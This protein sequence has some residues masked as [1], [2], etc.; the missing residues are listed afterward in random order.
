MANKRF[1]ETQKA[2]KMSKKMATKWLQNGY[3]MVKNS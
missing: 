1:V 2:T 3:K